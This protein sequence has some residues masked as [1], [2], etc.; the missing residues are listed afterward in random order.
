ML[1]V[2]G[3]EAERRL[4]EAFRCWLPA[5]RP[6][7]VENRLGLPIMRGV[8]IP[9]LLVGGTWLFACSGG[10]VARGNFPIHP[11]YPLYV[12]LAL[13]RRLAG[14]LGCLMATGLTILITMSQIR[15]FQDLP[16]LAETVITMIVIA[17]AADIPTIYGDGGRHRRRRIASTN[18]A[19]SS[20]LKARGLRLLRS[21]STSYM[22][23]PRL[24]I[25]SSRPSAP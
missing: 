5:Y 10:A 11:I 12:A 13:T 15:D 1:H 17:F 25:T 22:G 6:D 3:T 20:S 21:T 4:V 9:S 18:A 19:A 14:S 8:V 7:L 23:A 2:H 24:A 16:W